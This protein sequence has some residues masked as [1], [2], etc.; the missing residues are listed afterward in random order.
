M[1]G[2][3]LSQ[4]KRKLATSMIALGTFGFFA[5][6][7]LGFV[8]DVVLRFVELP[9]SM[10]AVRI[11]APDERIFVASEP[12]ARIQRYG[13]N[14]FELGF[15]V[16][17]QGGA[18]EVGVTPRGEI[19]VCVA[20]GRVLFLYNADGVELGMPIPCEFSVAHNGLIPSSSHYSSRIQVPAIAG[21]WIAAAAIVL[22][23]P[24]V[25]LLM[26]IYGAAWLD[27]LDKSEVRLTPL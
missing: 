22:W 14:G 18:F 2:S 17:S 13:P 25:A 15:H 3:T 6:I 5:P 11:V 19:L 8:P 16:T 1:A 20:R 9:N 23:H 12:L 21:G 7:L 26:A 24:F 27:N 4:V 10:G